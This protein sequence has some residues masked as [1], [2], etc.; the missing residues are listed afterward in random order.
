MSAAALKQYQEQMNEF[1][2]NQK[3]AMK[4]MDESGKLGYLASGV[5]QQLEQQL[6]QL[7]NN[8]NGERGNY[9]ALGQTPSP[10]DPAQKKQRAN[11]LKAMNRGLKMY[12]DQIHIVNNARRSL[13]GSLE[14]KYM[15]TQSLTR[16]KAN[17]YGADIN[18]A[19]VGHTVALDIKDAKKDRCRSR[20][21]SSKRKSR[22]SR[23]RPA[24]CSGKKKRSCKSRSRCS[25]KKGKGCRKS[26]RKSR[27]SKR[28][29]PR[30]KSPKRKSR[31]SRRRPARCSGKKKRSCRS[32]KR[33][34]Y[35]RS[36]K[37]GNRRCVRK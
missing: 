22:K 11:M 9:V 36:R 5:I 8:F 3:S 21:K 16:G 20:R 35:R 18:C 34:A 1:V 26:R 27:K 30:R 10:A 23:R 2:K 13:L 12:R 31:R 28:K 17:T 14:S 15:A 33:C 4:G 7:L 24:G 25:W 32:S 37:S 29:S 6:E 19:R